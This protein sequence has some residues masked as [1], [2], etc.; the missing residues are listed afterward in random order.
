M[1]QLLD[2]SEI[3]P[4]NWEG[5]EEKKKRPASSRTRTQNLSVMRRKLYCFRLCRK[6][7]GP[8]T[9]DRQDSPRYHSLPDRWR[10]RRSRWRCTPSPP[11]SGPGFAKS[12]RP[13]NIWK[14]EK[15]LST[16]WRKGNQSFVE[17]TKVTLCRQFY[18]H[19]FFGRR[20]FGNCSWA[21]YFA[22]S[23]FLINKTSYLSRVESPNSKIAKVVDPKDISYQGCILLSFK[24]KL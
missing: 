3:R 9:V 24:S 16:K 19:F 15:K 17:I 2:G 10:R 12:D 6:K 21:L 7:Y 11:D 14:N 22:S 5:R 1:L 18:K 4:H 13:S 8:S 23:N 20:L